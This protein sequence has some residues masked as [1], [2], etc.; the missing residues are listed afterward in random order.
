MKVEMS[1]GDIVDKITILSIKLNKIAKMDKIDN[2]KLINIKNEL[3]LLTPL[4]AT[5]NIDITYKWYKDLINI[6]EQLWDVEDKLR[7]Y[8][9][10][11]IFDDVFIEL[12]RSVYILNDKRS[13]IKKEINLLTHS[14]ITEVKLY[15]EYS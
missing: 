9:D 1:N 4:L 3:L 10:K 7:N 5:M 2:T 15:T 14:N 8:E 12:A 13:K 11:K 6:N